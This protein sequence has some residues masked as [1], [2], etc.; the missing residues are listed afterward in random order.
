MRLENGDRQASPETQQAIAH[1]LN[2]PVEAISHI[3][4]PVQESA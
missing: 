1:A 2:V 4:H 3:A